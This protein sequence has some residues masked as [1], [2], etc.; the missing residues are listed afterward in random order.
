MSTNG[1]SNWAVDLAEVGPIYPF[2][3]YEPLMV[4]IGV[5][6]W[7][8]WHR[9]QFVREREHLEQARHTGDEEKVKAQLERY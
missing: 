4:I 9:I 7:I 3:G 6:F 2:Q 5:I 1:Y 8:G